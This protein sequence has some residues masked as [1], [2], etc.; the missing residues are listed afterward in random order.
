MFRLDL[1]NRGAFDELVKDTYNSSIEYLG[2][3]RGTQTTEERHREFSNLVLK[4]KFRESFRFVCEREKGGVLQPDELDED[5]TGTIN[6]A[7]A[8]GL[9]GKH[10]S[11]IIPSYAT[12]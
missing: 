2:K 8:S 6:E 1:W 9:E 4:G 11:E 3:A 10:P 12:V 7:V 5:R